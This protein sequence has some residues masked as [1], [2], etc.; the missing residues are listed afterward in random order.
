MPK[1]MDVDAGDV[2]KTVSGFQY[3]AV[4]IE[5]LG[6]SEYTIVQ[7][8]VDESGSVNGFKDELEAAIKAVAESCKKSP[9]SENLLMRVTAFTTGGASTV[10]EVHGFTMLGNI[11]ASGYVGSIVPS[12]MT[13]LND[14]VME[15]VE[16][17]GAYGKRLR[18]QDYLC[19]GICFIVTDGA[20]NASQTATPEKVKRAIEKVRSEEHMESLRVIL[21]GINDQDPQL[22]RVLQDFKATAGLDDYLSVGEAT[23]GKLAKLAQWVSQSISSTSQ[24]LGTGGPS[25]S[26]SL[27]I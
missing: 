24:A 6:A 2:S 18:D 21:V 1:L 14:A 11:D 9:R 10:R 19:N 12:G 5:K 15:G 13:P 20:E 8:V 26:I 22:S 27:S 17:M 25:T 23:P 16:T 7:V 4:E 3:S